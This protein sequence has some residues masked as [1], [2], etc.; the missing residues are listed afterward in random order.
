NQT[1]RKKT[2]SNGANLTLIGA[3]SPGGFRRITCRIILFDE[4][5]GYP[6]GGAGAEGDQISLGIK[7]SET[8]WN[9]KI[10]IGSTPT[11]RGTSRIE[12]SF[13]DS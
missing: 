2:F 13:H 5:D 6:S 9:R 1:I 3:N 12:K 10:V 7:R 11:V 4:V 8:F